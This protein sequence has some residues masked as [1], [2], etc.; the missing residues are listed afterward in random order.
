VARDPERVAHVREEYMRRTRALQW[1]SLRQRLLY[2][3]LAWLPLALLVGYGY[4]QYTGCGPLLL[5]CSQSAEPALL[6]TVGVLLVLLV[7]VPKIAY[8]AAMGTIVMV[9]AALVATGVLAYMRAPL[10]PATAALIVLAVVMGIAYSVTVLVVTVRG[11][12][13][14]WATPR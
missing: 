6:V 2:A 12:P 14:R 7:I 13:W 10:P 1:P 11:G 4:T 3:L 9:A 8:V 5:E